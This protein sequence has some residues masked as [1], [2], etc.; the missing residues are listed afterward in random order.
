MKHLKFFSLVIILISIPAISCLAN[1]E[2]TKIGIMSFEVSDNL[3]ASF[4]KLMYHSLLDKMLMSDKFTVLDGD[5]IEHTLNTIKSHPDIS[6]QKAKKKMLK[7]LGIKKL[8]VGSLSK[9]GSQYYLTVKVLNPDFTVERVEKSST[10]SE[11]DLEDC[12]NKL[13]SNLLVSRQELEARAAF[14]KRQEKEKRRQHDARKGKVIGRNDHFI[15]YS[16]GL[17][18]DT[19]TGLIWAGRDN[20]SDISW[21][22]AKSFCE[23]YKGG[24][25][26]DWRMP[27][28]DEVAGLYDKTKKNRLGYA[29]TELI[30]LTACCPWASETRGSEAASFSFYSGSRYWLDQSSSYHN[31]RALPVRADR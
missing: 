19:K 20:G 23:N 9:I 26:T 7:Q 5:E 21:G 10:K 16:I 18:K 30:N 1:E 31:R 4:E 8:F 3:D 22:G 29:V 12:I 25:Y 13:S 11:N 24:G 17:V 15:A 2:K 28:Q 6:K 27:T 14:E